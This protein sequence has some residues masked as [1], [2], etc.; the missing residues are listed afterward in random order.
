MLYR[1][2]VKIQTQ[3]ASYTSCL[4]QRVK[5]TGVGV[6]EF[7]YYLL[8]LPA[9]KSEKRKLCELFA[10]A[11][12]KLDKADTIIE[13]FKI[14]SDE[15]TSF[16][17]CEIFLSI[18]E[19][20]NIP[21]DDEKLKYHEYL[22]EYV[23]KHKISEFVKINPKLQEYTSDSEKIRVK[24]DIT[25]AS[26]LDKLLDLQNRISVILDVMPGALR[27][28]SVEEGCVVVTL[29]ISTQLAQILFTSEKEFTAEEVQEFQA[30]S[31]LWLECTHRRFEFGTEQR[32]IVIPHHTHGRAFKINVSHS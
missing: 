11:K 6:V 23:R 9:F 15:C 1:N 20:F 4:C 8:N 21:H 16:L 28:L 29:L 26:K 2:W 7:R 19:N 3:F 17:N 18:Q 12:G 32:G 31:V 13:I 24:F 14:L 27:L 22:E 25:I 10:H 5:Q 30:L